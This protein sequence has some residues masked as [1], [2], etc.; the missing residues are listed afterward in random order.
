ARDFAW[1]AY[2]T[3]KVNEAQEAMRR[4]ANGPPGPVKDEAALFLSITALD[5]EDAI[6]ANADSEVT[7]TLTAQPDYTPALMA[8]AAI[9]L[10]KGDAAQASAIYN[11]ILQK[12]PDF[13][14][15]QKRLASIYAN[16]P[17][18]AEKAY[19]L[20]NKARRTLAD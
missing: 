6:P 19:D 17:A 18:N 13:A 5:S 15:A 2:A 4:V 14:P 20:P 10:Q 12:W 11:A 9:Q 7:K 3:G 1:A 16:E 8:R